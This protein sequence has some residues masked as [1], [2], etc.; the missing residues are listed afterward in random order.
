MRP[1]E[2]EDENGLAESHSKGVEEHSLAP[3]PLAG[4]Q[5]TTEGSG[6]RGVPTTCPEPPPRPAA[7]SQVLMASN[8]S[9]G[10]LGGYLHLTGGARAWAIKS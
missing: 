4:F 2:L 3:S 7:H 8:T 10:F 9:M 6:G 1:S 5:L